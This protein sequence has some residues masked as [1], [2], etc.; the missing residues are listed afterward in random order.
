MPERLSDHGIEERIAGSDNR[1]A[2]LIETE[3]HKFFCVRLDG[4]TWAYDANTQQWCE[5]ASYG[6]DNWRA[7]CAVAAGLPVYLGDDEDGTI[8]T[9]AEAPTDDG[10]TLES[11]WTAGFRIAGGVQAIDNLLVEA[12]VG[13]TG[14]LSG[15]GEDPVLE[16]RASRDAG[17][18]WGAWRSAALGRQGKHRNRARFTRCG[19]FDFPGALFEFRITDPAPRRVSGVLVNEAG[20]G[21]SR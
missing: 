20:G 15:Q 1:F 3:G 5:F 2:F 14:D 19:S 8:W 10:D 12:N 9:L 6:R 13:W 4:G 17:A 11:R 21:R 16:M 18:T 7:Q